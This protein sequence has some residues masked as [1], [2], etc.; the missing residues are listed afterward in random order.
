M[1]RSFL[2]AL[3]I[4]VSFFLLTPS[5][6]NVFSQDKS[7]QDPRF[8]PVPMNPGPLGAAGYITLLPM[9]DRPASGQFARMIAAVADHKVTVP[10]REMLGRFTTPG[11]TARLEQ[12]LRSQ[13][14]S[15]TDALVV[16]VDMLAYGGLIASRTNQVSIDEAKK[17]LEFFRW[18]KAKFPRVP[19]Y[20]YNVIGRPNG[21]L[22]IALDQRSQITLAMLDLVKAGT[23]NELVFLQEGAPPSG[24]QQQ[25]QS[26][27]RA[28]LKELGLES[29]V[30]IYGG[31]EEGAPLLVS[32][33][34]LDK[35][36]YKLRVAVVYSSQDGKTTVTPSDDHPLQWTV[37]NQIRA[38]GGIPVS[39]FDQ[40]DYRLF[41]N[42]PGTDAEQF[43]LFL[44]KLVKEL[45]ESRTIALADVLF[46]DP[47]ASGADQRI[48]AALKKE[49]LFDRFA[50]YAAWNTAGNSLG[51]A[52]SHANMRTFFRSKLNDRADRAARAEAAHL[53]F[54]LTR[55]AGD[56]LYQ[57]IVRPEMNRRLRGE[58]KSNEV[59]DDLTPEKYEEVNRDIAARLRAEVEKFFADYFRGR[60][61]R[62]AFYKG[63]EKTIT[64]NGLKDLNVYLPWPRTF[65]SAVEF[66]LD[67]SAN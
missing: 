12:W 13:D 64:V 5:A 50:G 30:P 29:R 62:L 14:Y 58:S 63:V 24:R 25:D 19:V 18:F 7:K 32:R 10:P 23:V 36:Q 22:N 47:S 57:D 41:V 21:E 45:K 38:A 60:T 39:E 8:H 16:S 61:H 55:F 17:R 49:N 11:E 15:K 54:L 48:I 65:E 46:P 59:T 51:T 42:A 9:D 27:L 56:Y 43:D 35:F 2:R 1:N 28:R 66:K 3:A 26:I 40:S 31:T 33:A 20:A 6:R 53:E 67:Y 52:I 37:E 34:V 44:K 4:I